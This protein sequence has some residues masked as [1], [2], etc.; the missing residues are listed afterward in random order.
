MRWRFIVNREGWLVSFVIDQKWLSRLHILQ[1]FE[2]RSQ[3]RLFIANLKQIKLAMWLC[4]YRTYVFWNH[5]INVLSFIPSLQH[6]KI[7]Q[8]II[9]EGVKTRRAEDWIFPLLSEMVMIMT[10]FV[11]F[12][13]LYEVPSNACLWPFW[14]DF[15][16]CDWS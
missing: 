12:T 4:L 9:L 10:S 16:S 13:V 6:Q 1:T 2:S 3:Q 5:V 7:F 11:S 14:S 15:N 8:S